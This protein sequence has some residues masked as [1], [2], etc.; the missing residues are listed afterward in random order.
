MRE[1]VGI[2]LAPILHS[3]EDPGPAGEVG[4]NARASEAAENCETACPGTVL[5]QAGMP[6]TGA[7]E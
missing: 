4:A 2:I 5:A 1:K 6:W 7:R 3:P